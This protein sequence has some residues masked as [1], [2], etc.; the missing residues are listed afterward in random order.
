MRSNAFAALALS[1]VAQIAVA[2]QTVPSG[3]TPVLTLEEAYQ[4]AR[5]N[6][7]DYQAVRNNLIGAR[8]G[9]RSAY[10][11]FLPNAD[12]LFRSSFQKGGEQVF[13]GLSLGRTSDIIQSSYGLGLNYQLNAA[14]FANQGFQR[15]NLKAVEAD[16]AGSGELLR[17]AVTQQYLAVLQALARAE[18]QDTLV[19]QAQKQVD[20]ATTRASV[21]SATQ[22]DVRRAEVTLGQ[23]EV[24]ALREHN[25]VEIEKLRLFQQMGVPQPAD[26]RLVTTFTVAAPPFTLDSILQL[27]RQRNPVLNALKSRENAASWNV[28]RQQGEYAPTLSINTGWG[29]YT[30]ERTNIEPEIA[31]EKLGSTFQLQNC[32]SQDSVRV[33]AGLS[34]LAAGCRSRYEFTPQDAAA[35]RSANDQYPFNFTRNPWSISAQVSLPLFDGFSREQRL[36]EASANRADA[37]YSVRARE[38]ALT[39]DVTGGYRNLVTAVR[40]VELQVLNAQRAREELSFAEERYRVGASTFLEVTDARTSFERA[41]SERIN[42]I[43]EYHR[44]YA[45]LES[46]VGRPL[47]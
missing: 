9:V 5:R 2:Q 22:L 27:A 7:P 18:L 31:G 33:A 12:V 30:R 29:G 23:A 15:A 21:G 19:V 40:A 24:N 11:D 17:A 10:G 45:Q 6:N 20:L 35:M 16:I 32:Y 37:R 46:A 1:V 34:S 25:N 38:L 28:R 41:E 3:P 26:V 8:A 4:L 13:G 43:Y 39:A 14:T 44:A 47:R 36:Q 42:A